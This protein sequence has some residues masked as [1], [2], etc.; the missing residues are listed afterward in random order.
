[1]ATIFGRLGLDIMVM[2]VGMGGR[3]DATD[4]ILDGAPVVSA[5]VN[6][7]LGHRKFLRNT[8]A[9]VTERCG[10]RGE[11]SRSYLGGKGFLVLRG[12][13]LEY[14]GLYCSL[15]FFN[16]SRELSLRVHTNY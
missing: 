6:I 7:G 10:S 2:E 4:A 8:V 13:V 9:E 15:V 16:L 5:P 1:V 11:G 14:P 12:P 3:L